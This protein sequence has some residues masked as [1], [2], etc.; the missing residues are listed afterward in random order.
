MT[1][2]RRALLR[3]AVVGSAGLA[4]VANA[5]PDPWS[6]ASDLLQ[7]IQPP[8]IPR[9]D[10]PI[11]RYGAKAGTDVSNAIRQAIDACHR[12]G[13]GRVVVPAGEYFTGPI[14]LKSRVELHVAVGATLRFS[15]DPAQY[16]VVFTRWEGVELMNYSP[17]VYAFECEDVAVT[18]EGTLDGQGDETHWWPWKGVTTGVRTDV[19]SHSDVPAPQIADRNR[20]F[21]QAEDGVPVE[22]RVYGPGHYLRPSF[23]EPYRCT[24][25]LVEGVTLRNAPFWVVHPTLCTNV[26]VRGVKVISHGPNNDGCDPE[27]CRGVLV[28]DCLFDTG[29]DC[30]ALKSGR[31]ADGRRVNVPVEDV[32]IRNCEMKEGHGGI[33]IG[34]EIS[35]GARNVFAEKC[36]LD[37]PELE[38]ALRFKTNTLRGGTIENV[39]VRDI[40]I[41]NVKLA[42]IEI[43]LRYEPRDSGP[44]IPVVRNVT[45][46]RMSSVRSKHGL[47]IRGLERAP[48]RNVVV[49]DCAFR[50]VEAGHVIEGMVD[51]TLSSMTV[52]AGEKEKKS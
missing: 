3:N 36:Q 29:D 20:L 9:V 1:L 46:E 42:P 48:V 43:D 2:S 26:T 23:I 49:R 39:Y 41:G 44:F 16:P 4:L 34:S 28:E 15:Q 19:M 8:R 52:E 51:L 35:G 14:H 12:K 30:I 11:A 27:S 32:I 6:G 31:N 24:R 38:R 40:R 47:F 7:R 37:S 25:V 21:Q 10:F 22:Q 50:G 45:V 17:L 33:T 13:G 5:S 18:G